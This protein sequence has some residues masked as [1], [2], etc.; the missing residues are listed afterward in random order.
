MKL[1]WFSI[2]LFFLNNCSFDNKTN[3]WKNENKTFDK[4]DKLFK[5]FKTISSEITKF[6]ETIPIKKNYKFVLKKSKKNYAWNDIYYSKSNNYH[7]F[8][9]DNQSKILLKTKKLSK[10][11]IG[12]YPIFNDNY[13][14]INDQK[15]NIIIFSIEE[16]RVIKKF[17][18]YKKKLKK[19]KKNINFIVEK[20]II[21]VSDNIGYLYAYDYILDKI[22]WAKNYKIPFRSNLKLSNNKLILADQN[23]NLYFFDKEEGN[24][25]KLFP[26][27]DV[28]LNNI[29]V[30][31]LSLS[32][33]TLLFLN[34][35]GSLYSVNTNTMQINWFVNLNQSL[36]LNPNN[37]FLAN[38]V[39][40]N[41]KK[42]IISSNNSTYILDKLSGSILFKKNFSSNIN[43]IINNNY[44]F[45]IT[46]NSFLIS[47]DLNNGNI[48]YSYD[49]NQILAE[50]LNTNKKKIEIKSMM[51]VNDKIY[52]YLK[53]PYLIKLNIN[54]KI[55][56]VEKLPSTVNSSPMIVDSSILYLN[57]QNKLI[58]LN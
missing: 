19:I 41:D 57:N 42:I 29:F 44:L 45:L 58:I 14:I 7:N 13:F 34:T 22:I 15:G 43:S 28:V 6:N 36:N 9:Y 40:N 50:Y 3:I 16:N 10:N 53:K 33:K 18:F 32:D 55:V 11:N 30:N 38:L 31:N 17:N 12:N 27:E 39:I 49:I 46:K 48:I 20:N 37:L 56:S 8:H 21:Y 2:I 47:L 35:Y 54:G 25:L 23:N 4:E 1:F 52:I 24:I 26:T 51:L 5:D